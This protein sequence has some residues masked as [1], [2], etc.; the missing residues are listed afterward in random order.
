MMVWLI[1]TRHIM[2]IKYIAVTTFTF[3]VLVLMWFSLGG[4]GDGFV[5]MT[6][7]S[8]SKG[9]GMCSLLHGRKIMFRISSD[10]VGYR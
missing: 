2:K 6:L 1:L 3:W 5:M 7:S 9:M 8:L 4:K 10:K